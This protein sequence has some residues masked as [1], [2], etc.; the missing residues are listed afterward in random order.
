MAYKMT[1]GPSATRPKMQTD[2]DA[3]ILDFTKAISH[4]LSLPT[5]L[6]IGAVSQTLLILLLPTRYAVLPAF[7]YLIFTTIDT[8]LITY[9]IKPN[10]YLQDVQ[11]G[12]RTAL[13]PSEDGHEIV[14]GG[15]KVA[16]LILG[17]KSNHPLGIFAPQFAKTGKHLMRMTKLFDSADAPAGIMGSTAFERRDGRGATEFSIVSYWRSIEDLL[18]FAHGPVHREAWQWWEK[19]LKLND[20]VGICHEI[21]EADAGA[22]ENVYVNFQ[23]TLMGATSFLRKGGKNVEGVVDDEWITPLLDASRGKLAK[24]SGRM[25]RG[26]SKYDAGRIGSEKYGTAEC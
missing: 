20:Y 11:P 10:P 5:L 21:F 12:R 8:A 22:W 25:G 26:D 9:N 6:G 1:I 17:A 3:S 18:E 4:N 15:Q 2:R 7:L 24:S 23:P 16:V 19:E 13:V 14:P